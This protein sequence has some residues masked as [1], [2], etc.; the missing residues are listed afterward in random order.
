[1]IEIKEIQ[2]PSVDIY[3]APFPS[4]LDELT[5]SEATF[6]AFDQIDG[7][8]LSHEVEVGLWVGAQGAAGIL[9]P[10]EDSPEARFVI[11]EELRAKKI[12]MIICC[13]E[14][15][16]EGSLFLSEGIKYVCAKLDDGSPEGKVEYK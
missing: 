15:E 12:T 9:M 2:Y 14:E 4:Y 13:S 10:F 16:T 7:Y 3:N 1:M 8:P 6:S 11:L 5:D